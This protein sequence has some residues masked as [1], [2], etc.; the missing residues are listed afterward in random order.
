MPGARS[1]SGQVA[2]VLAPRINAGGRMGNA[3]QGLRLLLARDAAEARDL[4]QSLEDDNQ[5]TAHGT[6]RRRWGRRR[7]GSRANWVG[8]TAR[9][10][11]SG[12]SAG[13]QA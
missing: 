10:S 5:L 2:F 6:T 13:T 3:E 9:R 11:C 4:A 1:P 12:R 8:P 7:S